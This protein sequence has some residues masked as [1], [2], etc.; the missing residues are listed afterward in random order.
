MHARAISPEERDAL[1]RWER[2][3]DLVRYRRARA[4]LLSEAHWKG[5][6]IADSLGL[7]VE[8]VRGL[9]KA[10]NQGAWTPSPRYR[11]RGAARPPTVPTS[12]KRRR[13]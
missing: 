2:A 13:T 1:G 3:D 6:R 8:T 12:V 10:F 4:L 5:A 11:A 7:H 9:I